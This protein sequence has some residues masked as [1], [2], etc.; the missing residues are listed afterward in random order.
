M[1]C[2]LDSLVEFDQFGSLDYVSYRYS[3]IGVV[4]NMV[5]SASRQFSTP[6]LAGHGPDHYLG[7][8]NSLV[9]AKA[10]QNDS[11]APLA[12]EK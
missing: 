6:R 7:N 11:H 4:L 12:S 10:G 9:L 5:W 8:T 1:C 2:R 3:T